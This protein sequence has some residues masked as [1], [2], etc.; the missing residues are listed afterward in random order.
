ME[1]AMPSN[2]LILY[3]PLLPPS[4]FPSIK[5]FQWVS[6]WQQ[7]A[8]VLEFQ[9]QHQSFPVNIQDW[10]PLVQI[11]M[12]L[13]TIRNIS[14]FRHCKFLGSFKVYIDVYTQMCSFLEF[15]LHEDFIDHFN[16]MWHLVLMLSFSHSVTSN[17][18]RPHG[19][20]HTRLPCLSPSPEACSNPCPLSRSQWCHPTISSSVVPFSSGLQS[21]RA[22]ESFQI[23][24]FFASGGQ[25][26][27]TS[28]LASVLPVNIQ[29]W[30]PL[31]L[32][33]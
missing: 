28:A 13:F 32:M 10:F 8:K 12:L 20:Q 4:T 27:G 24:W 3:H 7:V 14:F 21:F 2:Y 5:V 26:I 9:V 23:S 15:L 31:G 6:S 11:S 18:L 22:S 30:F 16:K 29:G 1:S 25:N 33:W 17:F 19:L